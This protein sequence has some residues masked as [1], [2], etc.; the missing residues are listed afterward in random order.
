MEVL[1]LMPPKQN[2]PF[3]AMLQRSGMTKGTLYLM[4]M[5]LSGGS[6]LE[7]TRDDTSA[8]TQA[9]IAA[10]DTSL[11]LQRQEQNF[12]KEKL[13]Q[14]DKDVAQ[15]GHAIDRHWDRD[16]S[17]SVAKPEIPSVAANP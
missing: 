10:L 5:I 17:T 7:K 16:R 8:V 4:G 2:S 12:M 11:Q 1:T 9:Q 3:E 13:E 15:I 6:Y 14:L